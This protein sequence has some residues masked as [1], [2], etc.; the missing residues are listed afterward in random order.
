MNIGMNPA[1]SFGPAFYYGN[2]K[3]HHIYWL[4]PISG[5]ILA[6]LSYN[7]LSYNRKHN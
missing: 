5:A 4:G 1:R 6:G 7:F 3:D 2:W